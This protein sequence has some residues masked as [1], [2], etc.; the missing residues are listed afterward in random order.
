MV[1][2]L[3]NAP[4]GNATPCEVP[5]MILETERL[6]LR[7]WLESDVNHYLVLAS[8]VGYHCFSP[9]GRFLVRTAEEAQAKVRERVLLFNDRKLGKFPIFLKDSGEFIGT[10]GLEPFDLAGQSE[11]ELGYRLCLKFWGKGYAKEAAAAMLSYGLGDLKLAR[12][13]AFALPQNRASL[14][15]LDQLGF[16]YLYD[17]GHA[18]LPHRL[19]ELPQDR[20]IA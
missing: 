13:M 5:E 7:N 2:N 6:V 9:P 3:D 10:C 19:Y 12:I 8:D 14:R 4:G 16:H 18:D 11:V 15:I 1:K 20:F 17:F